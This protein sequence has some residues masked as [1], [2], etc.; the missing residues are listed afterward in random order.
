MTNAVS[1][2][3]EGARSPAGMHSCPAC[4]SSLVQPVNWF[5]QGEGRWHVD[6]RCPECEWW[7]R[8]AFTQAE[9]DRFDAELDDG[10]QALVDGLRE[11]TRA[12]ME[13]EAAKLALA[14]ATDSILPEDF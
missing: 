11:L 12:N 5:E 6:L 7:G 3:D 10:A 14:L 4:S 1:Q 2:A 8:G 13:D 9:V